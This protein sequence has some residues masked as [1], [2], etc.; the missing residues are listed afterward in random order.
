MKQSLAKSIQN[1]RKAGYVV[2][3]FKGD[4]GG[5]FAIASKGKRVFLLDRVGNDPSPNEVEAAILSMGFKKSKD[6]RRAA[7]GYIKA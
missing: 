2:K 6:K 1:A 5:R 4:D 3:L 7:F